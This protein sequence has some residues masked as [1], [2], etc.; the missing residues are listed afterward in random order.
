MAQSPCMFSQFVESLKSWLKFSERNKIELRK[1]MSPGYAG[2]VFV[3]AVLSP[4]YTD[5]IVMDAMD[6][7]WL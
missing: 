1:H 2:A 3:A 5:M 7:G 4:S 6:D